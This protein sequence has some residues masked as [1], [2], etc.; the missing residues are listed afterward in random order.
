VSRQ[1][2]FQTWLWRLAFFAGLLLHGPI[3]SASGTLELPAVRAVTLCDALAKVDLTKTAGTEVVFTATTIQTPKGAFC[4]VAGDVEPGNSF[5]I[6]LP[7]EHWTQRYVQSAQGNISINNAGTCTPATNGDIVVG[8]NSRGGSRKREGWQV[9]PEKRIAFAYLLNHQTALMAK[10]LIRAFYGQAQRFA[11]FTGCSGGGREVLIEAQRYPDDF[12]G[13]ASGAPAILLNIHNGGFYHGWEAQ[14]N[15][16]ADGS[17]ILTRS[18][19]GILHDA[20]IAHCGRAGDAMEGILQ[21]PTACTFDPNWVQCPTGATDS[22]TCLTA[23]EAAVAQK[24]YA[25]AKDSNGRGFDSAGY[26]LGSELLWPLGGNAGSRTGDELRYLLPL[27]EADQPIA[28]LG[29]AFRFDDAWFDRIGILAPLYNGA[30]TDLRPFAQHG[31]KLI[32]WQGAEDAVVQQQSTIAYYQGVQRLVGE[33]SADSFLRFFLLPGVAHCI[34]GE[35]PAQVDVL[36]PLMAW[37]EQGRRPAMLV[38]G[39]PA[40]QK[41]AIPGEGAQ[42]PANARPRF[43]FAVPAQPA[44]LTRPIFPFPNIARYDGNGDKN[45]PAS[46]RPVKSTLKVPEVL[47]SRAMS[48]I[49]PDNHAFYHVNGGQLVADKATSRN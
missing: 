23:Q 2:A 40:N 20:A 24:L 10:Q 11:Y 5:E 37:V 12:N 26:P 27:P 14:V 42:D 1:R 43:P 39:K 44:M 31:G 30:D 28:A 21:M 45:N 49:G 35:G 41:L 47:N 38:A 25:G 33:Q 19:L 29:A 48:L 4:K 6:D 9:D 34:G 17:L 13:I 7:V 36:S 8:I 15:K 32:L 3:A 46:Y 16:R 18:R 22:T